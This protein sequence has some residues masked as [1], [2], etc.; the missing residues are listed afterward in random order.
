MKNKLGIGSDPPP[1]TSKFAPKIP[2][3]KLPRPAV[4]KTETSVSNDDIVD[5][6]LLAK[7][8]ICKS[9]DEFGRRF[10]TEKKAAQVHVS[11]GYPSTSTQTRSFE[12]R[13]VK[14]QSEDVC[15]AS[16]HK[17]YVEPYDYIHTYYPNTLPWRRPYSGD[18][19]VLN[20]LEFGEGGTAHMPLDE[21]KINAAQK[22]G[23]M[24][25]VDEQKMILL[26][27]PTRLPLFKPPDEEKA[28]G[29]KA[30]D[31]SSKTCCRLK[32]LPAG[33]MGKLLVYK[34]GKVK[35]KLGDVLFDVS[36]G[37][38]REFAEEIVAVNAK[39]RRYCVL[40]ELR[41]QAVVTPDLD[42]LV[43]LTDSDER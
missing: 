10:K 22:L 38:D 5:K 32:D 14:T 3:R 40:G 29:S 36:P 27:F 13:K 43:D 35:M 34:S 18:P 16:Q 33:L 30:A 28:P 17:E 26:Q 7:L 6:Q 31:A 23:F 12:P 41:K 20:R 39:E 8:N 9:E 42:S 4:A 11:F 21:N 19:E 25:T 24:E 37:A 15:L 1:R 2:V